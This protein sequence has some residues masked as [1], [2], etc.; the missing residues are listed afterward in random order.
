MVTASVKEANPGAKAKKGDV[1]RA[2]VIRTKLLTS[3][4]DGRIVGFADN[5]AVMLTPDMKPMGT[6]IFGPVPIEIRSQKWIKVMSLAPQ[7]V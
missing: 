2:L 1:V 7:A 6:R 5:A 3:R 4:K